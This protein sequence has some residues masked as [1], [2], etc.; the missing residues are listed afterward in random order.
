MRILKENTIGLFIDIQEKLFPHMEGNQQL[1]LNLIKLFEGFKVLEIPFLVTEQYTKG[2][3]PTISPLRSAFGEYEPIEK[4]AFSCCDEPPFMYAVNKTGKKN[5]IICG[6]ETHVCILQT[7]VDLIQEGFQPVVIEDCVSSR[8]GSD[9]KTAILRMSQEGVIISS[10]E[11][12]LFELTRFS[13]TDT[14]KAISKLLK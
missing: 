12:V 10:L 9:K 14:F 7:A 11:S 1:E 2:L 6:I 3:G 4:T 8:K 13:G 5:I